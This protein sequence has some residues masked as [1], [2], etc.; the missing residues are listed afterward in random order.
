MTI[1]ECK[2][3]VA[4]HQPLLLI[5]ITFRSGLASATATISSGGAI[6]S[7]GVDN[8]GDSYVSPPYV[9]ILGDGGGAMATAVVTDG[10]VTGVTV[11][12]GGVGYTFAFVVFGDVLF[13]STKDVT[14]NGIDYQGRLSDLDLE[15]VQMMSESGVD[16]PA[17]L[18]LHIADADAALYLNWE[19]GDGRGFRGAKVE[20]RIV[21]YDVL[22][23]TFSEDSVVRYTGICDPATPAD[24]AIL[25]VRST[26]R[27][28][29][30]MKMLPTELIQKYC[31]K[32]R[33]RTACQCA[34]ADTPGSQYYPCG[35]TDPNAAECNTTKTGCAAANNSP[36]FSGVAFAPLQNGG[37]GREYTSGAWVQLFN[38][39][40]VAKYGQPW[41]LV[42]GRGYVEPPVLNMRQDGNYTR[43]DV[44]L[45]VGHID[46]GRDATVAMIVA[47]NGV[48]LPPGGYDDPSLGWVALNPGNVGWWN[49]VG[50]GWRDGVINPGTDPYGSEATIECVIPQKAAGGNTVPQ[51]SVLFTGPMPGAPFQ[52]PTPDVP[53]DS[54]AWHLY[55]ILRRTG[56]D[57]SELDYDSFAAAAHICSEFIAYSSQ[58]GTTP[59]GSG[60]TG[61]TLTNHGTRYTFSPTVTIVGGGGTGATAV[62]YVVDP[63]SYNHNGIGIIQ[64][65][66]VTDPGWG[67]TSQPSVVITDHYGSNAA[68]TA[69]FSADAANPLHVRYRSNLIIR[70]RRQASE[71]IRGIRGNFAALLQPNSA[72]GQLGVLVRGTLAAQQPIPQPG[73]NYNDAIMSQLRDGTPANGYPAY[74]FTEDN[75]I[76]IKGIP[77]PI[78]GTP[79]RLVFQYQDAENQ[80]AATSM[81]LVESDD[82]ERIG[83]EV[84]ATA[85]ILG[86]ANT[87]QATRLDQMALKE[88]LRGNAN[89]DTRGTRYF[90]IQT[91]IR[92]IRVGLGQLVIATW[93]KRNLDQ[94]QLR[95]MGVQGPN[96]RGVITI[97][98][99]WHDDSWYVDALLQKPADGYSNP[100]RNKLARASYP[101]CPDMVGPRAASGGELQGDPLVDETDRTFAV[102]P[103]YDVSTDGV[104]LAKMRIRTKIGVNQFGSAHPPQTGIQA[105]TSDSGGTLA[106]GLYYLALSARDGN[107]KLSTLSL[108]ASRHMPEGVT[109]G[110]IIL[111]VQWWHASTAGWELFAGR[112][113]F[114]LSHQLSGTETPDR[115]TLQ[116]YKVCSWGA[117][118]QELD[119]LVAVGKVVRHSGITGTP[120]L[121][122][123]ADTLTISGDWT[124][125]DLAGRKCSILAKGDEVSEVPIL[126]YTITG[127]SAT[128]LGVTDLMVTPDPV[129]DGVVKGDV[130]TIRLKPTITDSGQ[131]LTDAAW[132]NPLENNGGG[133]APA[134]EV[135]LLCRILYGTGQGLTNTVA[136]A[137]ATSHT[138]ARAWLVA[139]DSTSIFIF[140]EAS[141]LPLDTPIRPIN[142]ADPETV[143]T[144]TFPVENYCK[145]TMLVGLQTEDGSEAVSVEALMPVREVYVYGQPETTVTITESDSPY[146][147]RWSDMNVYADCSDGPVEIDLLPMVSYAGRPAFM[148]K[149]SLDSFTVT[150][151]PFADERIDG[152][153]EV[154]LADQWESLHIK[155][156]V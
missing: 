146:Q 153:S 2:E 132:D 46:T 111:P 102:L 34:E 135:G 147:W 81:G 127:H 84:A 133:L 131:T 89:G 62:A 130:L 129:L 52:G 29:A 30:G 37:Y 18:T 108:I 107:G 144:L 22:S 88:S 90:E 117:P 142:N 1:D 91:S 72:T 85:Q 38:N 109:T 99:A 48:R 150:I 149:I 25:E 56:W 121:D 54:P 82:V 7:I 145:R 73:S 27:L 141:W 12:E 87:D 86:C 152:E 28:N 125:V 66:E 21:F 39:A 79:N 114:R 93:V 104:V 50:R 3:L 55:D 36:R 122:V 60:V 138:M 45:C 67:Y 47:V 92:A 119:A 68:A 156:N 61:I 41:P 6:D 43:M 116:D 53:V 13:L 26:N 126:N 33:P 77:R 148:K 11:D 74:H 95:V 123:A 44:G 49:W 10:V 98:A 63:Q 23:G 24:E 65:I 143:L 97:T 128:S 17:S 103:I 137:T 78:S 59:G 83:Q 105:S 19:E 58:Y 118:D 100:G 112:T 151:K 51:V 154:I 15:A 64:Y 96:K 69:S 106:S 139:P 16:V 14:Y 5:T 136:S 70:E 32:I 76:S 4:T 75:T 113:P 80:F 115:V 35:I 40:N 94:Q 120:L 57:A 134:E 101:V 20:A 71:I 140:E 42:L 31:W 9:T 155:S 8:G 124:G 110:S